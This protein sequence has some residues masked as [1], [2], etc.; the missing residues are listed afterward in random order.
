SKGVWYPSPQRVVHTEYTPS[1]SSV[2]A[3]AVRTGSI[4]GPAS[5]PIGA[6]A[7]SAGEGGFA[8][9]CTHVK[10]NSIKQADEHPSPSMTFPSSHPSSSS[11]RPLPHVAAHS[12]AHDGS[13]SQVAEQPS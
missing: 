3:S 1:P 12:G 11:T 9:T 6:S 10:P 13:V 4:T 2:P 8:G 7:G 5:G